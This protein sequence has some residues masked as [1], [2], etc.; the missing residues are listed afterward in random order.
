MVLVPSPTAFA[1]LMIPEPPSN[2]WRALFDLGCT[3]CIALDHWTAQRLTVAASAGDASPDQ[4]GMPKGPFNAVHAA[5][6]GTA[7]RDEVGFII[8]ATE[9][10]GHSVVVIE[11]GGTATSNAK[12]QTHS[13]QLTPTP[14]MTELFRG[15]STEQL[16]I[17]NP[18]CKRLDITHNPFSDFPQI[19]YCAECHWGFDGGMAC[20][21]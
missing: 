17:Q 18:A 20:N 15:L 21:C 3:I 6:A 7:E 2:M 4:V 9:G 1:V 5:M 14:A 19:T 11:I 12:A 10:P 13:T 16:L 8:G